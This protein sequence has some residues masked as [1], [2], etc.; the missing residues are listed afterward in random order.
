MLKIANDPA[1]FN[2]YYNFNLLKKANKKIYY[3]KGELIAKGSYGEV[4]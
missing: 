3:K 1:F 4:Y 2:I